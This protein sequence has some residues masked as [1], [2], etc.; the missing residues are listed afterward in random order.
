MISPVAF[1]EALKDQGIDF[2]TGVPDSLLKELLLLIASEPGHHTAANEGAAVALACGYQMVNGALPLVY[3]QNSG[4]GN[5]VNPL[6]SLAH[7][8]VYSIPLLLLVGHRGAPGKHDE[9]QHLAMGKVTEEMLAVMS[10]PVFRMNAHSGLDLVKDAAR[11]ARDSSAPVAILAAA[12]TFD[13]APQQARQCTVPPPGMS[14]AAA[15]AQITAALP[16]AVYLAT[17]GFTGRE[18]MD[19]RTVGVD[20]LNAGAMGHV[21]Q[22]ALG[23]NLGGCK[24][25]VV[26][27]DGDGSLLMHMGAL[28]TTGGI[29][30]GR[31]LHVVLNNGIH[32]SV[33]GQPV[34][35]QVDFAAA[36]LACGYSRAMRVS[37]EFELRQALAELKLGPNSD[38]KTSSDEECMPGPCLLEIRTIAG[39]KE[40]LGR[41]GEDFVALKQEFRRSLGAQ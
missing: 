41:P 22:I 35:G 38:S 21:S 31:F 39:V 17:T 15:L 37:Y 40:N 9:P 18:L 34:C 4:L 20:F 29:K 7:K 28:A 14:R 23:L 11:A 16:E 8:S 13:K 19:G 1:L 24:K 33:G 30:P 5:A 6:M 32:E 25:T 26:V 12:Q 2:Y 27:F 10:I 36:A 3:M